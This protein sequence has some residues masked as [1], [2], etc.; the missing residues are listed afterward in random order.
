[1]GRLS[2]EAL[3]Q[4]LEL[5]TKSLQVSPDDHHV[6]CEVGVFYYRKGNY[7]Q[8][9]NH[10]EK[11]LAL[12]EDHCASNTWMAMGQFRLGNVV[13]AQSWLQ[14]AREKQKIEAESGWPYA[15]QIITPRLLKE[16]EA[17]I[18]PPSSA[19]PAEVNSATD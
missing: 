4:V 2:E 10:F 12:N 3:D 19:K 6:Q 7:L 11:A 16:A 9:V 14:R 8:A 5:G 15:I 1:V 17:L 18:E 13:E